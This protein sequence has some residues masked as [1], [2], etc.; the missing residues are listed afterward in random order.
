MES[1]RTSDINGWVE[2][3]GNPISKVGVFPY[4]GAQVGKPFKPDDI[5]MVYRP[6]EELMDPECIESFKLVPWINDHEMLGS[7][8][9][10]MTPAEQKGIDGVIG[11]DV[12]YEAPYLKGNLKIFSEKMADEINV[13]EKKDLSIGYRCLYDVSQGTYNGQNYQAIQRKIRGNHLALVDEGRAGPDVAVLDHFKFTF[14]T[15][16]LTMQP[17]ENE[18]KKDAATV[19]APAAA[20]AA[21]PETQDERLNRMDTAIT[22]LM[23][24]FAKLSGAADAPPAQTP[25]LDQDPSVA[26][27][28]VAAPSDAGAP[29][30][31]APSDAG[32]PEVK[33]ENKITA[34]DAAKFRKEIFVE[35]AQCD[36][37][38]SQLSAH[39]GTFDHAELSLAELARYGVK[40]L[41]LFAG[42]GQEVAVLTGYLAGMD[43]SKTTQGKAPQVTGMDSAGGNTKDY[44]DKLLNGSAQ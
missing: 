13:N 44:F 1:K 19:S 9:Q 7:E 42:K 28:S 16:L 24:G 32:D 25:I 34:M 11:E 14:D 29:S 5:V 18:I 27:P 31:A 20:A 22:K 3:K 37:L 38:Y 10:G 33:D 35:R 2:I 21:V 12:Y 30:V 41:G 6:E 36:R 4:S 43:A 40:K 15:G 23:D 8:D 17:K 26:A 39:T